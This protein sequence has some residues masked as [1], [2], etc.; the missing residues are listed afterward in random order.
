MRP[1]LASLLILLLLASPGTGQNASRSFPAPVERYLANA[2]LTPDDRRQLLAGMAIA[3]PLPADGSKELAVFGAAWINA[4]VERYIQRLTDIEQFERGGR[5]KL[6]KRISSPPQLSDFAQMRL[7][8]EDVRDLRYCQVA[9]CELKLGERA[10]QRFQSEVDWKAA[11]PRPRVDALMRQL[12]FELVTAYLKGGNQQLA[13]YRDHGRPTSAAGEFRDMVDR[14]Q[15]L[16]LYAPDLR[17]YLLGYP[18]VTLPNSTSFLYWQETEFGLKPII[19]ITDM[20]IRQSATDTVV[21]AKMLYATHYFWT[22]LELRALIPDPARGPGFWLVTTSRSRTDG[23]SGLTGLFIRRRVRN[24][25]VEGILKVLEST[26]QK[27]AQP[28]PSGR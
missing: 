2:H 14:M 20:T 21:A 1:A 3:R 19:R 17:G 24:E 4:P 22:A 13:V 27:M 25:V 10:M 12:S 9:D 8:D 11:D 18:A 26:R 23:L 7:P 16:P 5:F 28:A 6:T 15:E